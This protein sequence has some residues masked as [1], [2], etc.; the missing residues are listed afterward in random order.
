MME[1]LAWLKPFEKLSNS[2]KPEL[3]QCLRIDFQHLIERMFTPCTKL[4]AK[5]YVLFVIAMQLD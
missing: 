3:T 1:G 2:G 5:I 4:D